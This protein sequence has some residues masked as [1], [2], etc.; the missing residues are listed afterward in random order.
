M[1]PTVAV[2]GLGALGLVTLKNL[3]EEGFDAVGIERHEYLGGLW[4]FDE[5]E[6]I[7]VMK[8]ESNKSISRFSGLLTKAQQLSPMV[9]SNVAALRTFLTQKVIGF[10]I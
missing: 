2:V 9:A 10:C 3:L 1:A 8:S 6:R 7:S 4:H 5:R